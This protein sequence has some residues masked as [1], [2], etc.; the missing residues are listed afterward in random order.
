MVQ[1]TYPGVYIVEKP[2]GVHTI[3]GVAT[4]MTGA[5]VASLSV[6]AAVAKP[7]ATRTMIAW[8]PPL[9]KNCRTPYESGLA[10]SRPPYWRSKSEKLVI[11]F[12]RFGSPLLV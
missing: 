2:S 10:R 1:L 3:T 11:V 5:G 8:V 4:S 9:R 7:E 6:Q 12:A